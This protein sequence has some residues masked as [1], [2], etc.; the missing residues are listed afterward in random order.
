MSS[1]GGHSKPTQATEWFET[2]RPAFLRALR[3]SGNATFAARIAGANRQ[4]LYEYRK[5]L[6][7]FADEWQEAVDR[8]YVDFGTRYTRRKTIRS[9]NVLNTKSNRSFSHSKSA[10]WSGPN[11]STIDTNTDSAH[12]RDAMKS[13][14]QDEF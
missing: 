10:K 11:I 8:H 14:P 2:H 6:P 5:I 4:Q 3:A 9:A 7:S 1:T 12:H 13:Q